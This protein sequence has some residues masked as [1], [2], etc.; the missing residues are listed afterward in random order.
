MEVLEVLMHG[1]GRKRREMSRGISRW[2]GLYQALAGSTWEN[3]RVRNE[4][5]HREKIDVAADDPLSR[6][7]IVDLI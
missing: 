3:R 6:R 5:E 2:I 1:E 7:N 4:L